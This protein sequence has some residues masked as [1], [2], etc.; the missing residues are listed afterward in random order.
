[1]AL[2]PILKLPLAFTRPYGHLLHGHLLETWICKYTD[3]YNFIAH[4]NTHTQKTAKK[5]QYIG[6]PYRL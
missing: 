6:R 3:I 1:M 2:F 4:Q 5:K